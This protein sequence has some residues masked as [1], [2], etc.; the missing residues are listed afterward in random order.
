LHLYD[1]NGLAIAILF[2]NIDEAET[3]EQGEKRI[4]EASSDIPDWS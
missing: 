4:A 1:Y 2:A 3:F